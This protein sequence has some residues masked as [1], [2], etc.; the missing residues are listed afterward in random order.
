MV[1]ALKT[2]TGRLV[3]GAWLRTFGWRRAGLFEL[4]RPA[5]PLP[6]SRAAYPA[7][8]VLRRA[9][10]DEAEA[11]SRVTGVPVEETVRRLDA[12]DACWVVAAGA[13]RP[14]MV[15][16]VHDGPFYVRGLG[17]LHGGKTG[18][19]YLYGAVTDPA[20][21][22]RGLFKNALED[23]T[24]TLFAN[25][26]TRLVEIVE[27]GNTP[28]LVTVTRLGR[29]RIARIDSLLVLGLRRTVVTPVDGGPPERTWRILP[30]RGR[31][32]I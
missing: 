18:E 22:G 13:S 7:G 11:C 31:F 8:Y 4:A 12:G 29:R 5:G 14:A 32:V 27:D 28:S 15:I 1:R 9:G 23:L 16:W 3:V 25:G 2:R 20:E 21:R 30:P 6:P 17:Y 26:A 19:K 24:A 10:R